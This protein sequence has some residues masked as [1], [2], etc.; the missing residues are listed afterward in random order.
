VTQLVTLDVGGTLAYWA[1]DSAT[2]LDDLAAMRPTH[3]PAV[4]RV[5]EKIHT[6][7]LAQGESGALR[8]RLFHWALRIGAAA[9]KAE[10]AG[11][12]GRGLRLRHALADRLVLSHVRDL[13]GGNLDLALTGAAPIAADVL[14]F[15]DACGVLILEGYGLTESCAAGTLNTTG[16]FRFGTVG[17]ALPGTKVAIADD[18]EILLGGPLVFDGYHRDEAATAAALEAGWLLTGDLGHVDEGG[19]L[20]ITGRKKDL[21]I[22]SS[23]K[24]I[25]PAPIEAALRESRWISQAVVAGDNRP[26]LVALLTIDPEEAPA[27]AAE[28]GVDADPAAMA[29]DPTVRAVLEDDVAAAN[30]RFARIEQIKRFTVLPHDL[31]QSEGDLTPTLKVK[32]AIVT[33]RHAAEIDALYAG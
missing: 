29:V 30:A 13:F 3:V 19:Y 22:T 10:R 7:A 17:R 15:F 5:F 12:V 18:G 20:R 8:S 31:S 28:L 16:A 33:E 24:N 14:A 26:Y 1:G 4:P 11:T 21:I 25:A 27:L 23:G 2:V 9:R 32:R 6:R